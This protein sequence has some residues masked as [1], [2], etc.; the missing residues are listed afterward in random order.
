MSSSGN[1]NSRSLMQLFEPETKQEPESNATNAAGVPPP[2]EP[3]PFDPEAGTRPRADTPSVIHLPPPHLDYDVARIRLRQKT[4][5]EVEPQVMDVDVQLPPETRNS[6]LPL[7]ERNVIDNEFEDF[8]QPAVSVCACAQ[9]LAAAWRT[10]CVDAIVSL[11][12]CC[13]LTLSTHSRTNEEAKG[14][15]QQA[16]TVAR[17]T[18]PSA[19]CKLRVCICLFGLKATS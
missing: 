3:V 1:R 10:C 4:D 16:A 17:A 6:T 8:S 9:H 15:P 14:P 2:V 19:P 13:R 5:G 12:C 7:E 18:T 11:H